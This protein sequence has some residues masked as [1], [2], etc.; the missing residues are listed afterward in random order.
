MFQ[1]YQPVIQQIEADTNYSGTARTVTT[2]LNKL[3]E[4]LGKQHQHLIALVLEL[5][6]T[7]LTLSAGTVTPDELN[8][9]LDR[10][11]FNDGRQARFV[12]TGKDLAALERYESGG[13]RFAE[14]ITTASGSTMQLRRVISV[15]PPRMAG[16]PT[17]FAIPNAMLQKGFLSVRFAAMT[18]V[19]AAVTAMVISY[20]VAA[21]CIAMDE[22]RIPPF[23]ERKVVPVSA[24]DTIMGER[25]LLFGAYGNDTAWGAIA[26]ADFAA[27][28]VK[29]GKVEVLSG[30]DASLVNAAYNHD[31]AMGQVGGNVG[32]AR[33][34]GDLAARE[35]NPGTP[36]A[37]QASGAVIQP[38]VYCQPGGRIT[39][40]PARIARVLGLKYSGANTGSV[41]AMTSVLPQTPENVDDYASQCAEA[42]GEGLELKLKLTQGGKFRNADARYLPYAL[43]KKRAA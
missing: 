25:L 33:S 9:V 24:D 26:A 39:K 8:L 28:T 4:D 30:V 42:T 18:A 43:K 10:I 41:F 2:K 17:D 29:T 12:G 1:G 7:T 21:I 22:L 14:P 38:V 15:G 20:K 32:D 19:D 36:T 23:V 31:M 34:A 27:M 5:D 35:I 37:L 40:V 11:E 6:L 13:R 16:S 3:Q